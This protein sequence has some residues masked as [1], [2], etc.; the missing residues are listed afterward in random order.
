MKKPLLALSLLLSTTSIAAAEGQLNL[1]NWG[2]YTS[3]EL[4]EKFEKETGIKVTVTD[5]DSNDTALAKVSAGGGGYD[6]VVPSA[7]FVQIYVEKGLIQKLDLSKLPHHSNI[8]PEWMDVEWDK[9]RNYTIP[10]QW[11]TTGIS[12]DT[13]I[14]KGDPNTSEIFLN[15]PEELKGKINVVPEMNEV[16]G[17]AVMWAG[18]KPCTEDVAV[19]KKAHDA[20]INARQY[21]ISMDYGTTERMAN[22]DWAASVN[23]SG[24]TFRSRLKNP[25]VVYGYPKEGYP[26]WMDSV[27]LLSDA[28][29][30]DEAYK[31]LDF[32]SLPEN[33]ALI[34]A[35]ARYPNGIS[36]STEFMPADMATAPE[37]NIPAEFK[38]AGHFLPACSGKALDYM[39]AIWTDLQK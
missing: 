11:G 17:L 3:P 28:K 9:G 38:A 27:A 32:I 5:Y 4:L 18:G 39:T 15:P 14:Y 22:G 34:S 13:S 1:F 26:L 37:V 33:A 23:W 29:N 10:W 2:D 35:F 21:W 7:H 24:E 25:N 19:L 30:V 20:L 12:V 31:F 36:G 8:A 16:V 6:L